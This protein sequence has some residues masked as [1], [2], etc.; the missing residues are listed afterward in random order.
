M[1][2]LV[3]LSGFVSCYGASNE[4]TAFPLYKALYDEAKGTVTSDQDKDMLKVIRR[5]ALYTWS[6]PAHELTS[7]EIEQAIQNDP[8][9]REQFQ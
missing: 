1:K 2:Y 5:R 3:H 6:R 8:Y 4:K 7:R 9:L